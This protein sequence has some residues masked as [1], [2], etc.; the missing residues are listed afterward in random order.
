MPP[1]PSGV[2]YSVDSRGLL[3]ATPGGDASTG[4]SSGQAISRATVVSQNQSRPGFRVTRWHDTGRTLAGAHFSWGDF[5]EF[6]RA[7]RS[8]HVRLLPGGILQHQCGERQRLAPRENGK[9]RCSPP[10]AHSREGYYAAKIMG[11]SPRK[12]ARQLENAFQS[13]NPEVDLPVAVETSEF[14]LNANQVFVPISA[15][16]SPSALP[17]AP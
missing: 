14:R 13:D 6:F 2:D 3:T 1:E 11:S 15:K 7:C 12:I 17:W 5:G 16:L 8:K 4:A 10:G 9:N